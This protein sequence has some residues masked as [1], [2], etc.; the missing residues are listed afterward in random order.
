MNRSTGQVICQCNHL[1]NFA[2]LVV[3]QYTNT[4]SPIDNNYIYYLLHLFHLLTTDTFI[5]SVIEKLFIMLVL[6]SHWVFIIIIMVIDNNIMHVILTA[7]IFWYI[8]IEYQCTRGFPGTP[9]CSGCFNNHWCHSFHCWTGSH[10]F[11]NVVLQVRV[12]NHSDY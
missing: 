3:S 1:T 2:I 4:F 12:S 10:H 6:N 8:L 7:I 5:S 11:L 9:R